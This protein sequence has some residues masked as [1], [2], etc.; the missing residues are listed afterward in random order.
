[1]KTGN[2]RK[3]AAASKNIKKNVTA[4]CSKVPK[5]FIRKNLECSTLQKKK[6]KT[7][8]FPHLPYLIVFRGVKGKLCLIYFIRTRIGC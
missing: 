6:N 2:D 1:M 7:I 3:M 8:R 5:A 4:I